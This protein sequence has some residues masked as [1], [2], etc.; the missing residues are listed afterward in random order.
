[1]NIKK[2]LERKEGRGK[3][4]N[5]IDQ[6]LG[7]HVEQRDLVTGD[8]HFTSRSLIRFPQQIPEKNPHMLLAVGDKRHH[9][10]ISQRTPFSTRPAPRRN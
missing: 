4:P 3:T 7:L 9:S 6:V 2:N 10:A 1:M 8:P 5:V